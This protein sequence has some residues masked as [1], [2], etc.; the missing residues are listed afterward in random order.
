M[1]LGLVIFINV[2]GVQYLLFYPAKL[3]RQR[4]T[5]SSP[6]IMLCFVCIIRVQQCTCFVIL[7][8]GIDLEL[9]D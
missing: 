3:Q 6:G 5:V 4:P 9:C 7:V 2:N 1:H 8:R